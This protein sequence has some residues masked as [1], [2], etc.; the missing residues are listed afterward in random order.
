MVGKNMH[1]E[2][3]QITKVLNSPLL[4]GGAHEDRRPTHQ[5]KANRKIKTKLVEIIYF[6]FLWKKWLMTLYITDITL[7]PVFIF[8]NKHY[9]LY[10]K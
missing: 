9:L 7:F 1:T 4:A 8:H 6:F 10:I 5:K 3:K 2:E